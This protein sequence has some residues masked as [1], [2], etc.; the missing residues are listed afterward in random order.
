MK[1]SYAFVSIALFLLSI[2][3]LVLLTFFESMLVD[4]SFTLERLMSALLLV[5]PGAA[6]IVFGIK[7]LLRHEG[8]RWMAVAGILLNT[9]FAG[10]NLLVLIFSG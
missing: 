6:G 9:L 2:L 10:F 1:W 5:L 8:R 7:S 3:F 4:L